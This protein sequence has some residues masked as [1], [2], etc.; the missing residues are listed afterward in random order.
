LHFYLELGPPPHMHAFLLAA[1]LS[2]PA[3]KLKKSP[4]LVLVQHTSCPYRSSSAPCHRISIRMFILH[5]RQL[6]Y[7]QLHTCL[8]RGISN[9]LLSLVGLAQVT[10]GC[11]CATILLSADDAVYI[12][13][14]CIRTNKYCIHL[15]LRWKKS[16]S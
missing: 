1:M 2:S 8:W 6:S 12:A 7:V 5:V 4:L 16:P 14:D 11:S 9:E 15:K 3:L 13:I 10:T